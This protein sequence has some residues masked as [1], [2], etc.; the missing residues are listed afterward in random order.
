MAATKAALAYAFALLGV[1][2]V[3]APSAFADD[4][5][6][7]K[8]VHQ[9]ASLCVEIFNKQDAAGVAALFATS[10]I[11]VNP[12]GP[13]TDVVKFAEGLVAVEWLIPLTPETK[14][15]PVLFGQKFMGPMEGHEPLIPQQ[16]VHYDLHAWIFPEKPNPLG[17]FEATNPDV[18]CDG[19]L[20][21]MLE[22]PTKHVH[23]DGGDGG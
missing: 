4:A 16:F 7:K 8:Q 12:S 3:I 22:P 1:M 14:E 10:A 21:D 5:D 23:P 13:Q 2:V 9:I 11:V 15:A 6:L 18:K 20:Y 17:M 19:Y